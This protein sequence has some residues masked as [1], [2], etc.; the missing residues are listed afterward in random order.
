MSVTIRHKIIKGVYSIEVTERIDALAKW[1]A[2]KSHVAR[3]VDGLWYVCNFSYASGVTDAVG[4]GYRTL[5]EAIG[6][7]EQA[8]AAKVKIQSI[9]VNY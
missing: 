2:T 5:K 1:I 4:D 7:L 9:A 8:N 3:C 6:A